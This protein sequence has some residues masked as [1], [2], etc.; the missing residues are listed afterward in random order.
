MRVRSVNLA[1]VQ[2]VASRMLDPMPPTMG[3]FAYTGEQYRKQCGW[4]AEESVIDTTIADARKRAAVERRG[5][6]D[7]ARDFADALRR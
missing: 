4:S 2:T 6:L 5:M 3:Y 7:G 1:V